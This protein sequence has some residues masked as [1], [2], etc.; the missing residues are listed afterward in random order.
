MRRRLRI[1]FLRKANA[2]G[3]R[4]EIFD[5]IQ[6]GKGVELTEYGI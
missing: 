2:R 5:L 3:E 6:S 4:R 1:A